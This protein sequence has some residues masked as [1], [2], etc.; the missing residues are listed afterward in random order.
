[1]TRFE[2]GREWLDAPLQDG[3]STP[4]ATVISG[5]GGAGKPLI[6]LGVVTS[7]LQAGGSVIGAPLQFPDPDFLA[8]A[9]ADLYDYDL[10]ESGEYVHVRFDPDIDGVQHTGEKALRANLVDPENWEQTLDTAIESVGG[11]GPGILFFA[12]A[13]NLPLLSPTHADP[14]IETVGDVFDREVTSLVCVSTSMLANRARAVG[15]LADTLV[16]ASVLE[17][18]KRLQ[19]T[20]ERQDGEPVESNSV[21]APFDPTLLESIQQRAERAKVVP[22]ETIRNI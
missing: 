20:V 13:L 15:D 9:A 17:A 10:R 5:P 21:E 3:I 4:S 11:G 22:T 8:H 1:M 12:T 6:A 19:F 7:W 14:L 18:P 16:T 2:T